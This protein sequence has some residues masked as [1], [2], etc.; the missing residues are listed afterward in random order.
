MDA[1]KDRAI[2]EPVSPGRGLPQPGAMFTGPVFWRSLVRG[3]LLFIAVALP[4]AFYLRTY[5]SAMIKLTIIQLSLIIALAAWLMGS[6]SE[7]RI[8]GPEPVLPFILPAFLLLAWNAVRFVFSQ[9]HIAAFTGFMMQE[10]FLSTFILVLISFSGRD[11]R[12]AVMVILSGW[13]VAVLYGLIQFSGLDPFLWKGAFGARVFSTLA[14]PGFFAG[15]LLLCGPLASA[16]ACDEDNPPWLRFTVATFSVLGAFVISYTGVMTEKIFF[17]AACASFMLLA[18]RSLGPARR[19]MAIWL[20]SACIIVCLLAS[21]NFADGH[22]LRSDF[23]TETWKGTISL[24]KTQP[25]AGSGP[26]SFW[27]R[28]PSFRPGRVMLIEHRH[29][30][31]TDHPE[32]ELLEQWSDGGI[33]GAVLWLWIFGLLLYRSARKLSPQS[34]DKASLYGLSLYISTAACVLASLVTISLRFPCPGWLI[35]FTAGLLGVYC[36]H[37]PG[38]P[39]T[40]FALPLSF[41]RLRHVFL[42]LIAVAAVLSARAA[43]LIFRS[44]THHNAAIFW[45]KQGEW[46][47]AFSE[48]DRVATYSPSYIMSQ[49]FKGNVLNHRGDAE[50][51]VEQYRKVRTLAP[52]Y[53]NVHFQEANALQKLNRIPEA[54]ECMERQV[55]I[56][57]VWEAAWLMLAGL[58][59]E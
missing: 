17:A 46:D 32:N 31:E 56:D 25:W 16:V 29:N 2:L 6:I 13:I 20:N 43:A 30:T 49:Y 45:S 26:G 12:R 39:E 50:R 23:I 54:I 57:P 58:Y 47:K 27:V 7:G 11:L 55:E 1:N 4:L 15:Y 34:Q 44:D 5:D 42:I 53:L 38:A 24:I 19:R 40:V 37:Q 18:V 8:E 28:Y 33:P 48:Y 21:V 9:Y 14:N 51:A 35:Y 36:A 10:I 52:D 3:A 41:G 22:K 59:K